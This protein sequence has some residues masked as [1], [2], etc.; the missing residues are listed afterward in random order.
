MVGPRYVRP[1]V[2]Q[3]AAFK[4]PAPVD[5]QAQIPDEW[6]RLYRDPDLDNLIATANSSNQTLRQ[7]VARVDEAR[8]LARVAAGYRYPTISLGPAY[9]RARTSGNRVSTITGQTVTNGATF[10]D[11]LVP[12]DLSYEVDVWGRVRRS[13][14]SARAQA[15]ATSDDEA[16]IRLAVQT[17]VA[18]Y[19]YTLRLLDAQSEVLTQ[20]VA[21]YREQVRLLNTQVT[22]GLAS[23]IVL[24]QAEAQLQATLAQQSDIARARADEEHAMAILCGQPA[25]SFSVALNPL[26]DS[27]PPAVPPGLPAAVL[28]NRPDVAEAEQAVVAANAQVGVATASLY[29]T[30]GLTGSAGFE[31]GAIQSL[32]DWRSGLWSVAEGLTAP[33]FQGGRLRANLDA[34]KALYRQ[35]VAA[36]VNQVLIAYGDVEDALTD[37]HALTTEV[38]SLREAVAASRNYLRL[39]QVQFRN[40]LVD[41]LTVIDAERTLLANQLSLTQAANM[42]MSASIHLIKA[43]GGGWQNRS[44]GSLHGPA[45]PHQ[46]HSPHEGD[47]DRAD[48][49][50]TRPDTQHPENPPSNDA[51]QNPKDDVDQ[52]AVATPLHDLA[53]QPPRYEPHDNQIEKTHSSSLLSGFA[54]ARTPSGFLPPAS[55]VRSGRRRRPKEL[56]LA[57]L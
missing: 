55:T 7:A 39:A 54:S 40:G 38:A 43:L 17:D 5:P 11:W 42:Q 31:S 3:P 56:R 12:V 29:P 48:Y 33:I 22:T 41:Y 18:Q 32:F 50:S 20:T 44:S 52:N 25:P 36:Y 27:A 16:V 14:Q 46:N 23:P 26:H 8:A 47:E 9:T 28:L 4:S 19:Y 15:V 57:R 35:S 2:D 10:S 45:D 1:P 21:S 34:T 24:N 6:W 53:R 37:L 51:A 13:L 49:S 30:F